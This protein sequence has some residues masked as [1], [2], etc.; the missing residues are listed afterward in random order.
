MPH[1]DVEVRGKGLDLPSGGDPITG[2]IARR[3]VKAP[4]AED[5]FDQV[6]LMLTREWQHG[7]FQRRNRGSAP[8]FQV[9]TVTR[10]AWWKA[11]FVRAPKRGF[12]FT[13][14]SEETGT[15]LHATAA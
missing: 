12:D 3:K 11:P 5:A 10:L 4:T 1:F 9:I 2:L 13:S 7:K 15:T 8:H 14:L 6:K